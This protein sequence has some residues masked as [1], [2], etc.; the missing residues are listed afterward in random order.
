MNFVIILVRLRQVILPQKEVIKPLAL[1][2]LEVLVH[3][4]RL[5]RAH[6]DANLA[7][8]AYRD[9]D[10]EYLWVKL[11]FAHVIGLFVVALDDVNA[12]RRTFLLAN[13]A[14]HAAQSGMWIAPVENEKRKISVILWKRRSL[15]RI[16]HRDQPVLL[17]ITSDEVSR[18]DGHSLE[19]AC[20]NHL[21]TST[22]A[23]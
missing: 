3:L 21:F 18:R 9:V 22:V 4:D 11:R 6:L 16:L 20:A 7:A 8:H 13:L 5:K 10:V 17:E 23:R 12:L 15:L 2:Q 14:C 1:T 19:Y